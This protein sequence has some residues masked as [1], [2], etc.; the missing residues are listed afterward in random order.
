MLISRSMFKHIKAAR[1]L[2]QSSRNYFLGY[3]N[4]NIESDDEQTTHRIYKKY[5][6][7]RTVLFNFKS[8][9]GKMA[10]VFTSTHS[11]NITSKLWT[12]SIPLSAGIAFYAQSLA[13]MDPLYNFA[14][15]YAL[16]ISPILLR[17]LSNAITGRS[18]RKHVSDMYLLHNGDQALVKTYDGVWHKI[19]IQDIKKYRMND[20]KKHIQIDMKVGDRVYVLS[21]KNKTYVNFEVLDKIIKG[22]CIQTN[23]LNTSNTR[24]KPPAHISKEGKITVDVKKTLGISPSSPKTDSDILAKNQFIKYGMPEYSEKDFYD[25]YKISRVDF[26]NKIDNKEIDPDILYQAKSIKG[27]N[28]SLD[29]I[30]KNIQKVLKTRTIKPQEGAGLRSI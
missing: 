17:M 9:E 26:I 5:A 20:K 6:P 22:I 16:Y 19:C 18:G 29:K 8:A 1:L 2:N 30:E 28:I 14:P 27:R 21:T 10:K 23:M 12:L 7:A 11:H 4:T 24:V 3:D 25:T 13:M 15:T